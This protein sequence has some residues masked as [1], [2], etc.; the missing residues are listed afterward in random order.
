[1]ATSQSRSQT[2]II[3]PPNFAFF[4][5]PLFPSPQPLPS[6][7]IP[8]SYHTPFHPFN[9]PTL[10]L[11][12]F[13][14]PNFS[15]KTVAKLFHS[16]QMDSVIGNRFTVGRRLGHGSFGEVYK[17][18]DEINSIPVAIKLE[19]IRTRDPQLSLEF[20][21]YEVIS[22]GVGIPHIYFYG[23][24][25]TGLHEALIMDLYSHPLEH[26]LRISKSGLSLQ[27]VLMFADQMLCRL[28]WIHRHGIVH[29]DVKPENFMVGSFSQI[30]LIDFGLSK[31]YID[32]KT[33]EHLPLATGKSL[34]GTARYSSLNAMRGCSQ[35]R[36]DDLESLGYVFVYLLKGGLPW[37]GF[38]ATN[39]RDKLGLI[40]DCKATIPIETLCEGLP[41]EF[42]NFLERTR[43]LGFEEE[44]PY[45]DFRQMFRELFIENKF[46]YEIVMNSGGKEEKQRW[47]GPLAVQ[48]GSAEAVAARKSSLKL[49]PRLQPPVMA[50][51]QRISLRNRL[52]IVPRRSSIG[53]IKS[54]NGIPDG[55]E[56]LPLLNPKT[57]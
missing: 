13:S 25:P 51:P 48:T 23:L 28:E 19:P 40:L 31:W 11:P 43:A 42:G 32:P 50:N 49:L 44:P 24:A 38:H 56:H 2:A 5:I 36:R 16:I 15:P 20:R 47:I 34:T 39:D 33:G 53:M 46:L 10:P 14:L 29:R 37:Q 4:S 21:I 1:L 8:F 41:Q 17:G 12:P 18:F 6:N 57:H 7:I 52:P 30:F 27:T 22:G 3:V 9:L 54:G 35:S 26:L 55:K 45:A